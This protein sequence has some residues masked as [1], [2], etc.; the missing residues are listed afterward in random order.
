MTC[1]Y[2][3]LTRPL[4]Q[5]KRFHEQLI[6]AKIEKNRLIISPMF[7]IVGLKKNPEINTSTIL[8]FTSENA[9]LNWNCDHKELF[10]CL[11]VG[12]KTTET[13]EKLGLDAKC[14]GSNINEFIVNFPISNN[15]DYYYLRGKNISFDLKKY[16]LKKNIKVKESIIYEQ[17]LNK[18]N[19]PTKS[20]LRSNEKKIITL[21]S[22]DTA[23][24]IA[25]EM[26]RIT[27]SN[28]EFLCL[29]PNI[30][31]VLIKYGFKKIKVS[32]Q[33]TMDGMLESIKN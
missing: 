16:L 8:I 15:Q 29:S 22:A 12:R 28:V 33:Q 19:E 30:K 32:N 3:I 31:D 25:N 20:L 5:A 21:F 14:L 11:C 17:Q 9:I 23:K 24:A 10:S 6:H 2:I 13:A 7:N 27:Y 26:E 1:E 4:E 18:L